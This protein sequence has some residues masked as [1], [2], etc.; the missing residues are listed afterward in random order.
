MEIPVIVQTRG[1]LLALQTLEPSWVPVETQTTFQS[2]WYIRCRILAWENERRLKIPKI[3]AQK[4][5]DPAVKETYKKVIG[6]KTSEIL[7]ENG[8]KNTADKI[9][10]TLKYTVMNAPTEVLGYKEET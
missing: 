8:D 5:E 4:F 7:L 2:K 6:E 3:K 10:K 1:L 9:W